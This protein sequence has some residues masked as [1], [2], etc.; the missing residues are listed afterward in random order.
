MSATSSVGR[1]NNVRLLLGILDIWYLPMTG[2][3]TGAAS[4]PPKPGVYL[5]TQFGESEARFSPDGRFVAYTS[6]A[7]GSPEVYVQPFPDSAGGKWMVSRGGGTRPVWRRNGKELF[8]VV[9]TGPFRL[10]AV[11]VSLT[12]VFK[13]GI[14]KAVFDFPPGPASY[15][16]SADGQKI[17]KLIVPTANRTPRHHR[18]RSC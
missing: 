1:T 16:V 7:S 14:P 9:G 8:Y 4:S 5:R 6:N 2:T 3:T 11:E 13:A 17:I 18:L 15:D 10:M 12:P